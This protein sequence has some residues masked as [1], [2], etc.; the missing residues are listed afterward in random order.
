MAE[1]TERS[2]RCLHRNKFIEPDEMTLPALIKALEEEAAE[3]RKMQEK[4]VTLAEESSDDYYWLETN[5]PE[6]AAE[7]DMEEVTDDEDDDMESLAEEEFA[8]ED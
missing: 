6:V 3:L 1:Q 7:F 5:D 4:G 8:D 2:F